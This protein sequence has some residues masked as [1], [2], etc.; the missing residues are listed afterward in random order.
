[1]GWHERILQARAALGI[2]HGSRAFGPPLQFSLSLTNRCN[3]RCVHCWYHSPRLERANLFEVR[4]ARQVGTP[5]P[6]DE[7][8]RDALRLDADTGQT[9][10]LIDEAA[11]M[12]VSALQLDANGEVFLHP[13]ALDLMGRAKAKGRRCTTYSNATLLSEETVDALVE[14]GFDDLCVTTL[15]GTPEDYERTHPGTG[16]QAFGRVR[17][18]LLY[19][20]ERKRAAGTARPRLRMQYTVISETVAG[21][22]G[23][24]RFAREIEAD[25]VTFLPLDDIGDPALAEL[26]PGADDALQAEAQLKEAAA[27]LDDA[28]V[29]RNAGGTLSALWK[30]RNTAPLYRAIPCY[31]GWL[32]MKVDLDGSV[33]PCCRC[34][35]SLGNAHEQGLAGVW[36]GEAYSRFRREARAMARSGASPGMCQCDRC[37]QP[38][39]NLRTFRALHPLRGRHF[40]PPAYADNVG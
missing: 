11:A 1:V 10:A 22:A 31:Y 40:D 34:Y 29:A 36:Y 21:L 37:S 38:V 12:G 30:Q 20:A 27:I 8:I 4:R 15:A 24:A 25:L 28:G 6:A 19:L 33:Y 35:E 14:M 5:P 39:A 3:V 18:G 13:D 2:A 17:D 16:R 7:E 26:R 23:F 9:A 32:S